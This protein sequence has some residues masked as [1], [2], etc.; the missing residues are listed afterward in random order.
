MALALSARPLADAPPSDRISP[1]WWLW[2]PLAWVAVLFWAS[3]QGRDFFDAWFNNETTGLLEL[4]QAATAFAAFLVALSTLRRAARREPRW[5][6]LWVLAATLCCLY[7]AGEEISWGQHLF[8]WLT[9]DSW[10][11]YN[12]QNETNLH[13][14]TAWLDQKPRHLLS[15]G[16][17]VGGILIPLYALWRPRIRDS[18]LGVI[19]PPFLCL[20][21]ALIAFLCGMNAVLDGYISPQRAFFIRPQEVQESFFYWFVLL[22]LVVLRRRLGPAGSA[23]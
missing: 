17:I 2:V 11:L 18:R 1:L 9:P 14:V 5:L 10:G 23:V 4:T 12:D 19:L 13:N 7:V 8:G 22:Y 15:A 6:L 21:T 3:E 16:T 20:P